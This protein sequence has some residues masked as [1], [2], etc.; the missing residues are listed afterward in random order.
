MCAEA[1]WWRC[2]RR[3]I[4]DYLLAAGETVFHILGPKDRG[5]QDDPGCPA[6]PGRGLVYPSAGRPGRQGGGARGGSSPRPRY[7]SGATTPP[8][9]PAHL[10]QHAAR[11]IVP[12]DEMVL[13]RARDMDQH[14]SEEREGKR[15]W[16]QKTAFANASSPGTG[17]VIGTVQFDRPAQDKVAVQ[18]ASGTSTRRPYRP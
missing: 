3:I 4:A 5:G 12:T 8:Q 2:H 11:G 6:G 9:S 10:R 17:R 1:V 18:P 16:I 14:Q 15:E 7:A 13:K